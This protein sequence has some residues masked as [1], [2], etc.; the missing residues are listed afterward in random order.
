MVE[1]FNSEW[2]GPFAQDGQVGVIDEEAIAAA[3]R[4]LAGDAEFSQGLDDLAGRWE[5]QSAELFDLADAG[6]RPGLDAASRARGSS[7]H[8]VFRH[9]FHHR[10]WQG[11]G[12]KAGSR[13]IK[14]SCSSSAW[15]ASKRS[16]GS[17]C[18]ME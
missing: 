2:L 1:S 8:D 11:K 10:V 18:G 12:A 6:E 13:V 4:D 9:W 15:A 17:R 3:S 5:A 16:K 7:T 14:I